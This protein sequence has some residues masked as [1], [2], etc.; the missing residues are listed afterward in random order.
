LGYFGTYLFFESSYEVGLLGGGGE[1]DTMLG[2][3]EPFSGVDCI[4][5]IDI[6][7]HLE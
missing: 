4:A 1:S 7:T 5:Q 2:K 6:E 3:R